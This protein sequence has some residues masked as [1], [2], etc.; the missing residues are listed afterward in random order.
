MNLRK[1]ISP[2]L[3][4]GKI[5]KDKQNIGWASRVGCRKATGLSMAV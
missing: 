5:F 3:P 2:N 4:I 1:G